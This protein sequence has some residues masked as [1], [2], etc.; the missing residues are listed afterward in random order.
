VKI[1]NNPTAVIP[2]GSIV[3]FKKEFSGKYGHV[4]ISD[5]SDL[6]DA[7]IIEQNAGTGTGTGT[8]KNAIRLNTY[9]GYKDI[10]GWFVPYK[11]LNK[12]RTLE[13]RQ[14]AIMNRKL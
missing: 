1:K 2:R 11:I 7:T 10:V 13:E 14:L 12:S 8:G 9:E 5:E 3:M 6:M 4:G